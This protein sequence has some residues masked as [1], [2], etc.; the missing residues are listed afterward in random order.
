M[1]PRQLDIFRLL[2]LPG[3]AL[4][5][6]EVDAGPPAGKLFRGLPRP[7][8]AGEADSGSLGAPGDTWGDIMLATC[9]LL[10]FMKSSLG[11]TNLSASA[12]LMREWMS[13][14]W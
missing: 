9:R 11:R 5:G 10:S 1:F 12:L 13:G 6:V 7:L 2:A 4:M 3:G 8:T 14:P